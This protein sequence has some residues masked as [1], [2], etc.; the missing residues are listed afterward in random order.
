VLEQRVTAIMQTE[1]TVFQMAQTVASAL[2]SIRNHP[3]SSYPIADSNGLF[4]GLLRREDFHSFIRGTEEAGAAP[5][6]E[7]GVHS[8]PTVQ[9][10]ATVRE[11]VEILIRS[12][13]NKLVVVDAGQ[14][15]QGIVTVMDLV[16]AAQRTE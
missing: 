5:L 16:T 8:V 3:H 10:D 13:T 12:A 7:V 4:V 6:S 11:A 1:L 9:P 14:K 2:D 15:L